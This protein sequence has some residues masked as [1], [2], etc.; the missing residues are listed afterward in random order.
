VS[1]LSIDMPTS[2]DP[3]KPDDWIATEKGSRY[4]VVAARPVKCRTKVEGCDRCT[5][6][7]M[8]WAVSVERLPKHEPI[9]QDVRRIDFHWHSRTKHGR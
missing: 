1:A 7:V 2:A 4:V 9:P 3:I 5:D 6:E 8:R